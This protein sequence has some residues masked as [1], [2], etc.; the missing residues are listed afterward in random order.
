MIH[1]IRYRLF[2]YSNE[3]ESEILE[4]LNFLF[5]E[6]KS[7]KEMAE[8]IYEK[9]IAIFSGKVDKKREIKN[10]I[11]RF[12]ESDFDK[13]RFLNNLSRK[14]DEKG[15]LFLRFSKED[16]INEKMTI[17]DSGDSIHLKIKIAAYPSRKDVAIKI[18]KDLFN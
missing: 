14:I 18:A 16:A 2:V 6:I 17:L 11:S 1:N 3:D 13:D 10:F 9:P 4:G 12:L 7:E 8:G 15:N 5:P